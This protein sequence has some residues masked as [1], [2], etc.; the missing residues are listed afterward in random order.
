[1]TTT[2]MMFDDGNESSHQFGLHLPV[3]VIITVLL[4]LLLFFARRHLDTWADFHY[5]WC[6]NC[7]VGFPHIFPSPHD[8]MIVSSQLQWKK[9]TISGAKFIES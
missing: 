6:S 8:Q 2:L 9:E 7:N 3:K 1:M 4:L 5:C